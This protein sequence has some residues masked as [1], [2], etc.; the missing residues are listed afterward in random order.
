MP[1]FSKILLSKADESGAIKL[2]VAADEVMSAR[3]K[4]IPFHVSPRLDIVVAAVANNRTGV[5]ILLFAWDE[6]AAFEQE[7]LLSRR[8]QA[9]GERAPSS[10]ASNNDDVVVVVCAHCCTSMGR[11]P[12]PV[13]LFPGTRKII[14]LLIRSRLRLCRSRD[15]S[16]WRR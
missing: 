14:D 4:F 8:R 13:G 2:G 15:N 7:N 5:P 6:I 10:A 11:C 9:V 12:E 16:E 1:Q 3:H